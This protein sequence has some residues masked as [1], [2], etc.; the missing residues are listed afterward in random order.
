[1][2]KYPGS[3]SKLSSNDHKLVSRNLHATHSLSDSAKY[4][5][6]TLGMKQLDGDGGDKTRCVL[7]FGPDQAKLVLEEVGGG[8]VDHKTA[9][10]RIAFAVPSK[11]QGDPSP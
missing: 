10:G 11:V 2:N 3:F 8:K 6:D 5:R 1:M 4:W 7:E 9:F